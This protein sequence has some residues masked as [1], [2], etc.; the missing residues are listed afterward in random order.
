MRRLRLL[1]ALPLALSA[2]L[3]LGCRSDPFHRPAEAQPGQ[4][5][6]TAREPVTPLQPFALA[7]LTVPLAQP[8]QI[9]PVPPPGPTPIPTLQPAP[10]P[11][12]APSPTLP[13][14]PA[15]TPTPTPPPPPP[16]APT[17]VPTPSP[18]PTFPPPR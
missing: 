12:P 15:P 9:A 2:L 6:E 17:P 7:A 16:P 4:R 10:V 8:Q 11:T 1:F 3:G 5:V 14:T 13:P 18:T